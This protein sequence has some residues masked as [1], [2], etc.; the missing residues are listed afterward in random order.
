MDPN[1]T[2]AILTFAY[3]ITTICILISTMK[4]FHESLRP[5][6][7][8]DFRFIN[9]LMY[10]VVKNVGERAAL[11]I[12]T[13]FFPDVKF[14]MGSEVSLNS[15]PL[16][17]NLLFLGPK[18]EID[19]LLGMSFEVLPKLTVKEINIK[20]QYENE[21]G[22]KYSEGYSCS[23]EAYS[24]RFFVNKNSINDLVKELEGIKRAITEKK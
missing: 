14:I 4:Q 11:K 9:Q 10:V 15:L 8:V 21:K 1:W 2:M 23:L 19:C 13:Q 3:V 24:R 12:H 6:V 22:K 20:V 16:V 7:Y 17:N 18:E 5:K